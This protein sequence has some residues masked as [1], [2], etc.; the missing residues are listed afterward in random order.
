MAS[1]TE[2]VPRQLF[3]TEMVRFVN[4]CCA[5]TKVFCYIKDSSPSTDSSRDASPDVDEVCSICCSCKSTC[6][7][8][9]CPC[10]NGGVFAE[11]DATV[12]I[13]KT[14]VKIE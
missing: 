12:A 6:Q 13:N 7:R 5:H 4:V 14:R 2:L 8:R 10:K 3:P 1:P 9:N 11:R